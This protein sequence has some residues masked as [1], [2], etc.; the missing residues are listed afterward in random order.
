MQTLKLMPAIERMADAL[1]KNNKVKG[2]QGK[3]EVLRRPPPQ[4]ALNSAAQAQIIPLEQFAALDVTRIAHL[5]TSPT[6]GELQNVDPEA[7]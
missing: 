7:R 6:H 5:H 1:K 4:R 3:F 2:R